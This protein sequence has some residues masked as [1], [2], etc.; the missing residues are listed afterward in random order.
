MIINSTLGNCGNTLC[1]IF[2]TRGRDDIVVV[3]AA[4]AAADGGGDDDDNNNAV[5]V[6]GIPIDGVVVVT[7]DGGDDEPFVVMVLVL[8]GLFPI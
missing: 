6:D 4:T 3:A 2:T 1:R 5:P 8:L 7:V